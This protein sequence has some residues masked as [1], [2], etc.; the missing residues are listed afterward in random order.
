MFMGRVYKI[1]N[2]ANQKI[3][4]GYTK[5]TLNKRFAKHIAN[6]KY[7]GK[8]HLYKA[9][10]KHGANNFQ[11]DLLQ[12]D[13]DFSD[14]V[15][16]ISKL[17]PQYNMTTGGEGGDTSASP[18]FKI[19]VAKYHANKTKESYATYGNLGKR[20][21]K[22]TKTVQSER[23]KQF[24]NRDGKREEWSKRISG[25]GNPMFGKTPKNAIPITIDGVTYPSKKKAC[26][27]LGSKYVLQRYKNCL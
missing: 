23:R 27:T 9:I 4:I 17:K 12:E 26:D 5:V 6:A 1:T 15:N 20:H 21:S 25:E 14:E 3:Y 22:E 8:S 16:W 7:G 19:G 18:N 13:A 10:R 2:T 11:I 24:W